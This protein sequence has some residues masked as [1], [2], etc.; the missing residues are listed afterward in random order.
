VTLS[1]Y[2]KL[3]AIS[4]QAIINDD[5]QQLAK[6][7]RLMGRA[8]KRTLGAL[9]Y[10]VLTANPTMQ[11]GNALF[12]ASHGNLAGS[13]A[14][15]SE[16]SLGAARAAMARQTDEA[17]IATSVGIKPKY[18]LVPPEL[19][20]LALKITSAETSPGDAGRPPNAV[21]NIATPI[22][23]GRLTGTAWYLA[24]D[25]ADTDTIE[26]TYLNGN[27]EPVL[28]QRAGWSVDGAEFKVRIDAAV[29]ALHWRGLF[30]NPGA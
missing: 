27:K 17:G 13:G 16:A 10:G 11:D 4:R 19:L 30:K 3:F 12:H 2:G 28:E 9:V 6:V 22:S 5:L 25:P 23:D 29:K 7:P 8:A 15:I 24:A 20:D 18:L 1:T 14:A 21:R 26:V